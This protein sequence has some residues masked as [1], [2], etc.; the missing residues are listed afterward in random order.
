MALRDRAWATTG[1]TALVGPIRPPS[2]EEIRRR[3]RALHEAAPYLHLDCSGDL[4]RGRW[5]RGSTDDVVDVV[6]LEEA[7]DVEAVMRRPEYLPTG[8]TRPVQVVLMGDHALLKM[9]HAVGDGRT[10]ALVAGAL[11]GP[12]PDPSVFASAPPMRAPLTRGIVRFARR[13]PRE[14]LA[15][16]RPRRGAGTT[17]PGGTA[18]TI[19]PEVTPSED[20]LGVVY[21]RADGDTLRTLKAAGRELGSGLTTPALELA[22]LL[23]AFSEVGIPLQDEVLV[24]FDLRRYVSRPA[25]VR[26]NF[27]AGVTV[28]PGRRTPQDIMAAFEDTARSGRPLAVALLGR[29]PRR[30]GAGN[31]GSV[32]LAPVQLAFT[33]IGRPRE[34]ERLAWLPDAAPLYGGG[35]DP[36]SAGILTA[37]VVETRGHLQ[38]S[39][40]F[41]TATVETARVEDACELFCA[42]PVRLIRAAAGRGREAAV[43][44]ARP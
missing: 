19:A 13:H 32:R 14:F 24:P 15:W 38:V 23:E 8:V 27:V 7:P 16:A 18:T 12:D 9:S 39:V 43:A 21:R 33:H 25:A 20:E 28:H 35:L 41:H 36:G 10:V 2:P 34:F 22:A 31:P 3:A 17:E 11:L 40:T 4:A 29:L 26:G 5:V 1:I 30:A 6:D 37:A 44:A 42:D